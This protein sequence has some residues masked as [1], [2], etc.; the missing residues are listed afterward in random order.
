M[1]QGSKGGPRLGD[2]EERLQE[3]G[4]QDE[5]GRRERATAGAEPRSPSGGRSSQA[6]D[7]PGAHPTHPSGLVRGRGCRARGRPGLLQVVLPHR[8]ARRQG[9]RDHPARGA[10]A[11]HRRDP[12]AEGRG[13]SGAGLRDQGGRRRLR[14]G[15]EGRHIRP[16]PERALR[17]ADRDPGGGRPAGGSQGDDP[18]GIHGRPDGRYAGKDRAGLLG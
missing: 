9:A 16:A 12:A 7:Q 13:P 15:S 1:D 11:R 3:L 4:R 2:A 6:P 14:H 17:S 18:R 8:Q 5:R 10:S